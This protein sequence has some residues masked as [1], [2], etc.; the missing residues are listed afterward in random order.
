MKRATSVNGE[1]WSSQD[2]EFVREIMDA[3]ADP[4]IN[5]ITG[6][7]SAQSGKTDTLIGLLFWGIAEDP[8]PTLWAT[9]N[10]EEATKLAKDRLQP[11]MELCEPVAKR[12]P[13]DRFRKSTREIYFP[14]NTF[15]IGSA[16]TP[17]TLQSTPFMR[18]LLDEVRSWPPG[19]LPMVNKRTTAFANYTRV[20]ISTPNTKDDHLDLA[21]KDG[22]QRHYYVKC[23]NQECG[24]E[25]EMLWGEKG[26]PGGFK[27]DTNET[28]KPGGNWDFNEVIKTIRYECPHCGH[29]IRNNQ[30]ERRALGRGG[31]WIAH[32]PSAPANHRSYTWNQLLP[33]WTKWD[34]II[35]EYLQA[36]VALYNGHAEPMKGFW[37][38]TLGIPW[39]D[40]MRYAKDDNFIDQRKTDYDPNEPWPL[41]ERALARWKAQPENLA[42]RPRRICTVDVQ[43]RGGRHYYVEIR[44][45]LPG[46]MSR[47]VYWGIV[48]SKPELDTVIA[49]WGVEPS[50]VAVDTGNWASEIYQDIMDSGVMP[51]G[52]YAWKAM[53]GDKAPCYKIDGV[54]YLWTSS[55]VDPFL[56]DQKGRRVRPIR[57]Y[58]FS[59]TGLLD[60]QEA[61][62]RGIGPAWMM[63]KPRGP[64]RPYGP[65]AQ[66]LNE[67]CMQVTAYRREEYEDSYNQKTVKW[68]QISGR[69]D[70]WGSTTRMQIVCAMVTGLINGSIDST[71]P[72]AVE[73]EAAT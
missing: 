39:E 13:E 19:A 62:M 63:P 8:G 32:N 58:L 25:F 38:E 7:C 23:P 41:Y 69:D 34:V 15:I 57:Q 54:S 53:K 36:D 49:D 26:K 14:G 46:G 52:D 45:W 59:K 29:K 72:V 10:K 28:T 65:D 35:R 37:T 5:E 6:Q 24:G 50:W 16:N 27:W 18:I 33:W 12:F 47:L 44:D 71:P 4:E 22:D 66:H 1:R 31:R 43:G 70:H 17:S 30:I 68:K 60:R 3:Y 48:W 61:L 2:A 11:M 51:N 55:Y 64:E 73:E 20:I 21:F 42:L 40:R 67:F 9:I 56:G